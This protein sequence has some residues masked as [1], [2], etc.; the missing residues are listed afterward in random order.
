VRV[1]T[2]HM[3]RADGSGSTT[4]MSIAVEKGERWRIFAHGSP[5]RILRTSVATALAGV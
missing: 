4:S 3:V 2:G 1:Q 5:R